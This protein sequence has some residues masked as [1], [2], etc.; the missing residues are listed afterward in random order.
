MPDLTTNLAFREV[1]LLFPALDFV[2]K[3]LETV[4]DM[5]DPRLLRM[6]LHAQL[7]QDSS[8]RVH[9]SSCLCCRLAGNH[10]VVGIPRQLIPSQS[11]LPIERRQENVTED[12]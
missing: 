9:S 8:G 12:G 5:N 3:K 7:F 6:Q 11:H 4:S 2:A 10:P 1:Q